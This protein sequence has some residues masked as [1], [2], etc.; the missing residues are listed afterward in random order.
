[1][2]ECGI[3]EHE[4]FY[5]G[6]SFQD[7]S[8]SVPY[9]E[10]GT[11]A[12]MTGIRTQESLRRLKAVSLKKNDNYI[13]RKG[14]MAL[15]HPIYDWSS[16]DVWKLINIYGYDYN[17]TYDIYSSTRMSGRYLAQRV[18]P[19]F[20]EEPLRGLWIYAECFPEMW[21]K[22]LA[23]VRGVATA[24]RYSNTEIYGIGKIELPDGLTY[25]EWLTVIIDSYDATA[26]DS[27]RK[28]VQSLINRHVDKTE[29]RIPDIDPHPLTGTCWAF[30]CKVCIKGDLKGRT[31][32]VLEQNGHN[33]RGKLG[34]PDYDTAVRIYGKPSYQRKY[35]TQ[36]QAKEYAK[37]N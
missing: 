1:M 25:Q 16:Q 2:P 21:H 33:M 6:V 24:W 13:S 32:P 11:T 5:R 14:H 35:F 10:N 20:G 31:T 27:V 37:K 8:I 17:K 15:V 12:I 9:P 4:K 30:I 22:M 7:F 26:R 29:D 34:I 28:N 18:C 19:P 36:K 3:T 23:R